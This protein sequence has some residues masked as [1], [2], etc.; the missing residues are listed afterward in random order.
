MASDKTKVLKFH[1][2]KQK[3]TVTKGRIRSFEENKNKQQ[4]P[5]PQIQEKKEVKEGKKPSNNYIK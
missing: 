5:P 4:Q 2:S 1:S 3:T